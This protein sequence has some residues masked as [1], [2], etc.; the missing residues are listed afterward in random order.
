MPRTSKPHI[1]LV[2][3]SDELRDQHAAFLRDAGFAVTAMPRDKTGGVIGYMRDL[4]PSAVVIDLDRLPSHGREVGIS[5]RTSKTTRHIPL[6][7][8]GGPAEKVARLETELPAATYSGWDKLPAVMKKAVV[9]APDVPLAV[10]SHMQRWAS[11]DLPRKLGLISGVTAALLNDRHGV[12]EIFGDLPGDVVLSARISCDTRLA[13]FVTTSLAEI[14]AS[15]D[16]ARA[17]LDPAA[18]F[19]IF[20]PKTNPKRRLDFNQEHVR[21]L[22]LAAGF[23]DYKVA[24][25]NDDW[26]ALKFATRKADRKK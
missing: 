26:S 18:S 15:L 22:G 25:I 1:C 13:I 10:P 3:W 8:A 19:W 9:A 24:G 2:C 7:F 20:H 14:Q 6:I 12:A 21:E 17:Q 5:L 4:A 23:V 11:N 16:K